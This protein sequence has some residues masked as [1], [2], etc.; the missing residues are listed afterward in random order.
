MGMDDTLNAKNYTCFKILLG[1][2]D[3]WNINIPLSPRI[4]LFSGDCFHTQE[5]NIL[6]LAF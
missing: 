1:N 6:S 5:E 4:V 3:N 2:V